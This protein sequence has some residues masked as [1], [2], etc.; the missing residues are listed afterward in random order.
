MIVFPWIYYGWL[1]MYNKDKIIMNS[2]SELEIVKQI[3]VLKQNKTE[4]NDV[5]IS[6]TEEE[7]EIQLTKIN[8]HRYNY[9]KLQILENPNI[10]I[11]EKI[12]MLEK[13]TST[14]SI[15][16]SD[17]TKGGLWKDWE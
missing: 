12:M 17:I 15:Y 11:I 3:S 9:F 5:H 4:G 7:K 14:S 10:S 2:A 13:Y 1:F 16:V 6:E 8:N